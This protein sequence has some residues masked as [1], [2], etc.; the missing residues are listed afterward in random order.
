[1]GDPHIYASTSSERDVWYTSENLRIN[2]GELRKVVEAASDLS[3]DADVRVSDGGNA[4]SFKR[5]DIHESQPLA[6]RIVNVSIDEARCG[7]EG[8]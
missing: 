4:K 5:I 1:M 6:R 2:L 3:D 8:K 7:V